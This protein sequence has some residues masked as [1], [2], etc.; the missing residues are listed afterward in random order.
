[1]M[2]KIL[3]HKNIKLVAAVLTAMLFMSIV[4]GT[5]F[6][7]AGSSGSSTLPKVLKKQV[8]VLYIK[9]KKGKR[10]EYGRASRLKSKGYNIF[11][12][13]CSD[14]KTT[15]HVLYS[16]RKANGNTCHI[17]KVDPK[18]K[19]VIK[20]SPPYTMYHGNDIAY[21]T[22]RKRLVIVHGDGDTKRI[23][24]FSPVT[25]KRKKVVRLSFNK[26]FSGISRG[27]ALKIKGVTGIAYDEKRDRFIASV[28]STFDYVILSAG[29]KPVRYIRT[30][31]N[32]DLQKQ[33]MY[34]YGDHILRVMNKYTKKGIKNYIYIYKMR[35][36][37]VKRVNIRTK[38]EVESL[39]FLKERMYFST[40]VEQRIGKKVRRYSY[41]LKCR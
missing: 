36:S 8:K 21:D 39:Y 33:G 4:V 23:S 22:K 14:G 11:Q 7:W 29:F 18:T 24:I 6:A 2:I 40:Y 12:G 27:K 19:K 3:K 13:S 10:L 25:L 20:V 38:S 37:Y 31:T 15:Y 5:D 16:K 26:A 28:K 17:I 1:M 35:G 41:I 32:G 9:N 30:K 34:V